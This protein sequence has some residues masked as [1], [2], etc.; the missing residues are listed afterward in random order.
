MH[1]TYISPGELEDDI[2]DN[3]N[4]DDDDDNG[5]GKRRRHKEEGGARMVTFSHPRVWPMHGPDALFDAQNR[6]II[7][8]GA[9]RK[10]KYPG[11][12]QLNSTW[13]LC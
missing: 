13:F 3:N 7:S 10:R 4:D 9:E 8:A 6:T 5:R 12:W 11:G 1:P 2:D